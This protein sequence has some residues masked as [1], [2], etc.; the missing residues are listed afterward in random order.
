MINIKPSSSCECAFSC[1]SR[2]LVPLRGRL[3]LLHFHILL[4]LN[5]NFKKH[6]VNLVYFDLHYSFTILESS[7]FS[8]LSSS[9]LFKCHRRS[10][11]TALYKLLNDAFQK[12]NMLDLFKAYEMYE[13]YF[14]L[15]CLIHQDLNPNLR[16]CR[17]YL[18]NHFAIVFLPIVLRLPFNPLTNVLNVNSF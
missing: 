2:I 10:L 11:Q 18:K 3:L 12:L 1:C 8:I 14:Q 17:W 16:P 4:F 5:E 6:V 13:M 9:L 15:R 7:I